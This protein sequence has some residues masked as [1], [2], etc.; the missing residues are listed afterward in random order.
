MKKFYKIFLL[1]LT[2][3]FL[4]TYNPIEFINLKKKNNSFFKIKHLE[5]KEN[6]I[7]NKEDIINRLSQI[8]D[9]NIFFITKKDIEE[10]LK[11]IEFL[12]KI[13]VKKKYPNTIVIKVYETKPIAIFFKNNNKYLLDNLSN[14]ISYR[15]ESKDFY[16]TIFGKGAEEN[17]ANFFEKLEENNFP[18]KMV[19]NYYYFQIGRWD[20]QLLNDKIIKLPT[21]QLVEAFKLATDLLEHKNFKSYNIIDLR[22]KGKVIVE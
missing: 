10:P 20:L 1:L 19:K 13:E 3:I 17:F 9:K 11:K 18:H 2:L 6:K 4:T 21:S 5:V 14:L 8:I 16:P 15:E 22:I 7:I 12:G